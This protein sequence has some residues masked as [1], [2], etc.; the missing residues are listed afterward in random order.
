MNDIYKDGYID[1]IYVY[2]YIYI[3]IYNET[4]ELGWVLDWAWVC[5]AST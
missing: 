2:I 5:E 4:F 3:Y 1:F